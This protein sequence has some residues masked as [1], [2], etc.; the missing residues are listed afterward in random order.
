MKQDANEF[1]SFAETIA[2]LGSLTKLESAM[3][4]AIKSSRVP[5]KETR[6]MLKCMSI[7]E[8]GNT[9]LFQFMRDLFEKVG[10]GQLVLIRND[11]FRYDF[12]IDNSPVCKLYPHVK[13]KKTCY[14]TAESL[15]QFFTKDLGL[16]GTAEEIACQNAGDNRCEFAVSLQPLAV[17][18][19]ALDQLDKTIIGSV[20]D[21]AGPD[22]IS[23][24]LEMSRDEI[25]FRMNILKR[26]KILDDDYQ[27]TEIGETY[28]KYGEGM[29]GDEEEFQPPW[30]DMAVISNAISAST[31]FAE[32]F[33]EAASQEPLW[34]VEEKDIVNLA[35]QAKKSKSFAELLSKQVKSDMEE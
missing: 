15:S 9:A 12:A 32:A 19:L 26:Y 1:S 11:I 6:K 29:G 17:Y 2:S 23:E 34:D 21:G 27:I 10:V 24:S 8:A 13:G 22:K 35:E 25:I 7:Q 18:Q 4:A 28:H 31:S 5:A 33:T 14:I 20:I 30:K 16:P 3:S